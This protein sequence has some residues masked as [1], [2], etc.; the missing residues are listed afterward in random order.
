MILA[1]ESINYY[2]F[3]GI[4]K[5]IKKIILFTL[6]IEMIGALI[7]SVRFVPQYG[8]SGFYLG[9]FHSISAFCN[10]GFDLMS[11]SGSGKYMSL[12]QYNNDP[13]V[14]Y[15]IALLIIVGGLGFI[16]WQDLY[17]YK[18]NKSLFLHTKLVLLITGLLIVTGSVL[19]F[20]FESNNPATMGKLN[21]TGKINA[22]VFHSVST[23][24]AGYNTVDLSG[25]NDIS[26]LLTILFMFIGAAPGSTAGGIKVTTFGIILFAVISQIKG[27]NVIIVFKRRVAF[28]TASKALAIITLSASLVLVIS[29]VILSIEDKPIISILYEVV[30]AFGTVGL[31]TG[32][33]PGLHGVSKLL[34]ILMMFIGR[35]GPVSFAMA[36]TLKSHKN[37][38]DIIYPGGRVI[39]R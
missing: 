25:M 30:S 32:M 28:T 35:V 6:S 33:T 38:S 29:T 37:D 11:I 27:S 10:A 39:I 7:L 14:I 16:V 2:S 12:T 21:L 5:I 15:T 13:V 23:R 36:L 22:S 31:T 34:L 1:Q 4:L 19:F 20:I 17:N 18:K 8:M 9:L 3:A 24:T 26:K